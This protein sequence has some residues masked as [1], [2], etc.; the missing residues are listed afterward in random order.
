MAIDLERVFSDPALFDPWY[1]DAVVRVYRYLHG[2]C[3]GDPTLAEELTQETFLQAIR[4]RGTFQGRAQVVTWLISIARNK[5][6][7]HYRALERE[8]R[9]RL[10]LVVREVAI[11]STD[12]TWARH[13]HREEL[14]AAMRS[15][16]AAQRAAVVLHY[17]DGLS[18]RDVAARLGR[19][20]KAIESLLTRGREGLRRQLEVHDD[21]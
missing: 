2:R 9:R 14:L 11:P 19:S 1:R 4:H 18:V 16:P 7:D 6:T 21:A 13:E 3:A 20:E 8:E 10:R 17:V 15:L 12:E 5:L